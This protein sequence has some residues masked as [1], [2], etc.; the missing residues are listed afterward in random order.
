MKKLDETFKILEERAAHSD[1]VIVSF[2]G[3]KDSLCV[4]DLCVRTFKRVQP[5][6][7]YLIPDLTCVEIELAKAEDRWGIPILRYPHWIAFRILRYNVYRYLFSA[8]ETADIQE[9]KL[10][11]IY[12][13]VMA[14]TGIRQIAYG[15][16]RSDS[17]WRKRMMATGAADFSFAPLAGW[18]KFDVLSYLRM[19]NIPVPSGSATNACGIDLSTPSLLWMHDTH[20]HDFRKLLDYFPL[21]ESVVYRRQFYGI[22]A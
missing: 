10:N 14:D 20:P 4:M 2:S 22:G 11:D 15:G 8:G 19:R 12:A 3:G 6:F 21:A 13:L 18:N 5:F 7:M 1:S 17:L 9:A 16:K